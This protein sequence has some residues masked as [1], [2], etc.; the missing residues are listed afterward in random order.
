MFD[1]DSLSLCSFQSS[2]SKAQGHLHDSHRYYILDSSASDSIFA[3]RYHVKR[4]P[5]V[6]Y[7]SSSSS[8][9]SSSSRVQ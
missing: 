1:T 4:N 8:S 2:V 5:V 6:L 3:S 9:S 7:G